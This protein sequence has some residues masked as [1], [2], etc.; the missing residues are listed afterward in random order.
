MPDA[1]FKYVSN[2]GAHFICSRIIAARV[3][4]SAKSDALMGDLKK[5]QFGVVVK[6]LGY[7]NQENAISRFPLVMKANNII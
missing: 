4:V 3:A 1:L 2:Q 6:V 5:N 7:G